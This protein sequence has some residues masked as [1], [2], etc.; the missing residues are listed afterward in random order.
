VLALSVSGLALFSA[1]A[2]SAAPLT[3]SCTAPDPAQC[4]GATYALALSGLEDLGDGTFRYEVIFGIDTAGYDGNATDYIRTVS[5]K[6]I[7]DDMSDLTLIDAPFGVA[8]WMVLDA[9]LNAKGCKA[10]NGE[11][12]GCAEAQATL[13]GGY[14]APVDPLGP[15][16][17]TQ[18]FWTFS[19]LSTDGTPNATGHIKY[20]YVTSAP[21][22][23]RGEYTKIGS[24]GSFDTPLQVP[25]PST[26]LLLS[27]GMLALIA[28]RSP[29]ARTS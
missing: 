15:A 19:F 12:A 20:Q 24:L 28:R 22:D 13:N 8:N 9:G 14:G 18:Y 25:E 21:V 6:D 2:A 11:E 16:T 23:S 27:G 29:K 17:S 7:V 5:F 4:N 3:F 10:T 26:L 1:G